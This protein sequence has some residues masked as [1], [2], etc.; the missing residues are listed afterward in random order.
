MKRQ[1]HVETA[2]REVERC[3]SEV[4]RG[5]PRE[6]WIKRLDEAAKRYEEAAAILR[7]QIAAMNG[8]QK[9]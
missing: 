2:R 1:L 5:S 6:F 8:P 7:M 3:R 9:P 4:D